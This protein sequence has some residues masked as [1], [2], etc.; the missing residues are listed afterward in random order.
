MITN[1]EIK[2]LMDETNYENKLIISPMLNRKVQITGGV[3][4]IR[5]GVAFVIPISNHYSHFDP[6]RVDKNNVPIE[7]FF[8]KIYRPFKA[9]FVLN[10][11]E[12]AL[13][14]TMEYIKLPEKVYGVITGRSSWGKLGIGI[15]AGQYIHPGHHGCLTLEL[16]NAGRTTVMIYPGMRIGQLILYGTTETKK[17]KPTK[18]DFA[19]GPQFS[20]VVQDEESKWYPIDDGKTYR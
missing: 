14:C 1:S 8:E 7:F 5:L 17:R 18:Y 11:G 19:I 13:G 9:A 6:V 12:L 4:D 20:R 2:S 16:I 15:S 3:I 10:S